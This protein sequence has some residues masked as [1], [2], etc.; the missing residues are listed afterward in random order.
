MAPHDSDAL[1]ALLEEGVA[2]PPD[3]RAGFLD[4]ACTGDDEL[5][6][7]L[8]SLLAAHDA[9]SGY[10]ERVTE[11]IIGP[12]LVAFADDIE[13]EFS[14]RQTIAQYRLLERLGSGGMGVVFKALD[15][16]LDRFVALKFLTAPLS[17]NPIA[18]ER[19]VAEAK[20][21]SALDHPNIGVVHDIGQ[22]NEGRHF[23][24]MGYYEGETLELKNERGGMSVRDA[25]DV[26]TQIA[27][28][29]TAAHQKGIIHRDVK[30]SNILITKEGIAK[31]LDFG[32]AKL[33]DSNVTKEGAAAGTVAY[34]SPEQTRGDTIDQRTDLWSL[35]V[36][37]YEML[38]GV[39]PFCA[40]ND[41]SLVYAIR[42][43]EWRPVTQ[44]SG[45]IP[46]GI[47]KI[48]D[49]CLAKNP[50][51]RYADARELLAD[52]RALDTPDAVASQR[53][54][55]RRERSRVAR[56]VEVAAVLG[57]LG[58]VGI[59]L[60]Q[61]SAD[62]PPSQPNTPYQ[63]PQH[64]VAVLPLVSVSSAT[65]ES[66]LADGLTE[67]LIAHL[68]N[69]SGLRVIARSS[70]M[71]YKGS[72]KSTSEIGRELAVRAILAGRLR[73][74]TDQAQITLQLVDVK[75]HT[76]LWTKN[77][78]GAIANLQT[79]QRDVGLQVAR[80]LGMQLQN[81]EER[82]LAQVGTTS[83]DAY[84]LYLKGRHFLEKRTVE[85]AKQAQE[86]FEQ[87]L[88]LDPAFAKAWVGLGG[89]F[90]SL[91][92]LAAMRAADAYPRSRAA[93]ERAL[94]LDPNL[95]EAHVCL[96]TALTHYYWDFDRAADHYQR[97]LDLNPSYADGHRL[98]SEHLRFQG[99]FDEALR[100]ARQAEELDPLSSA[101]QIG[102][103]I[104]LYW[105]RQYDEAIAEWRRILDV[106]P[107]FSAAY[108]YLALAHVQKHQHDK[109][110]EALNVPGAGGGLQRDT[111]RGYIYAVTSRHEEARQVLERLQQL[112]RDQ[113]ISPWHLAIVHL[114]LGE[115]DR[116]MDLIE[117]AYRARDWQVRMLPVEP[118]LDGL[119]GHPR[120]RALV[121]QFRAAPQGESRPLR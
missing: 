23:I 43:D 37:L 16:R 7:E 102:T 21:A 2:L 49:R 42:H 38:A 91:S 54:S 47:S 39:R 73:T 103:G 99:R 84:L 79:V 53:T 92:A 70:V 6:E 50:A 30:P 58:V 65:A 48:L 96:A 17:S 76:E 3:A 55:V 75:S 101:P 46:V 95:S 74:T 116:A 72:G 110:L 36:V 31:L 121:D 93:A 11:Q 68:S 33:A 109:A 98:D 41:E 62:A 25:V 18:K 5:R 114:G 118:L 15:L 108:F 44:A 80:A 86:Y 24:V 32:I 10:F 8:T 52:L 61:R 26:V 113:N 69:I 9:A 56:Y 100:E 67:E 120:F 66:D 60:G 29:L 57:V 105:S 97:A 87:A 77:Y 35:G 34:M 71:R 88:D 82:R 90:S 119:R 27:N 112:S 14:I 117:E 12:A 4:E 19:L 104:V 13:V 59:Y 89:A 85:A 78:Q 1:C 28:A 51:D 22:T 45:E 20:A 81:L 64:R 115:H 40:E 94:Q 107:R 63:S 83:S 106:N 111:L